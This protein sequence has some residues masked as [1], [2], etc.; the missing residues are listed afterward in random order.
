LLVNSSLRLFYSELRALG[1]EICE[2]S[3]WSG[4][5]AD[6]GG[7]NLRDGRWLE[8]ARVDGFRVAMMRSRM[9]QQRWKR[10]NVT[11]RRLD[12]SDTDPKVL[13]EYQERNH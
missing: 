5:K 8:K 9:V 10:R 4:A 1:G 12:C 7:R 3:L 6:S 13:G 11:E 2:E